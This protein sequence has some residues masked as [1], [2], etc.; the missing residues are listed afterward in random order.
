MKK[1]AQYALLAAFGCLSA[2]VFAGEDAK[3]VSYYRD[4]VPIFKRSCTGCHHPGKLK[5]QLDLTTYEAFLKGGKHGPAFKPGD[6]KSSSIIEEIGGSEPNMPKEGD[7]LAKVEVALIERWIREGGTNDTPANANSF[8]LAEPPIYTTMP[9]VSALAFSPDGSLLAVS[10]Y[11]EVLLR[12][13]DGSNLIARLVGESPR[14]E[15]L[16]FNS[17]GTM[18]AVAGSAPARFGEIQIW[19]VS[20]NGVANPTNAL[21]KSFKISSDSIYGISF[22]PESERVAV[23]CADKTVRI[24]AVKDGKE[25]VK[26]DN[27]S[28][29][30]FGTTFTLNGKRVLTGSRDRA[31]KLIDASNGQFIDDINKLLEPVLCIARHP[32]EDVVVYGGEAGSTRTYKIAE[33][34]GRTAANNDVNIIKNFDRLS[35]PVHAVAYSA[36]GTLIASGGSDSEVRIYNAKEGK[37]VATLKGH[38]GA[39]FTLA[40]SPRTNHIAAAGYDGKVRIYETTKGD[41]I[42]AFVPVPL[43]P[44][45]PVQK[46]AK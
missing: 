29:W 28:D 20:S 23:G 2:P 25:L 7:P 26:L 40:F 8:K 38:E 13:P 10:G 1:F 30:V 27:H 44:S 14:I 18:L 19:D 6:T 32:K 41:L 42:N 12:S 24:I 16:A 21:L 11:H 35:G 37:R 31:M 33:N 36:D 5:G 39:I 46:A 9:V 34:Q 4:V 17:N 3:P 45:G 22:S 15:S 43:S